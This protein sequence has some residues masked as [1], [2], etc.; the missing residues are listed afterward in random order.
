MPERATLPLGRGQT[1]RGLGDNPGLPGG[2]RHGRRARGQRRW[3]SSLLGPSALTGLVGT[4]VALLGLSWFKLT[5]E[6]FP[7]AARF[8][9]VI[10]LGML[11]VA[12]FGG[13]LAPT[14]PFGQAIVGL[15]GQPG[16]LSVQLGFV[17]GMLRAALCAASSLYLGVTRGSW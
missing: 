16:T 2:A 4:F 17:Y 9:A 5:I 8:G 7:G 1:P 13:S 14:I 11:V 15:H 3:E 6:S 12:A 10:L